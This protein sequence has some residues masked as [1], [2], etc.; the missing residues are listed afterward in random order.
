[1]PQPYLA[2]TQMLNLSDGV[3]KPKNAPNNTLYVNNLNERV[4]LEGKLFPYAR[5][6]TF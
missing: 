6:R 1:M 5:I 3:Y 2:P 4:K